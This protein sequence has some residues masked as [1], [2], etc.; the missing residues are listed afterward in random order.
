MRADPD[1]IKTWF[2]QDIA[3]CDICQ[4][5]LWYVNKEINGKTVIDYD[6]YMC[7]VCNVYTSPTTPRDCEMGEEY[8]KA[9]LDIA[10]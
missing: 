2:I 1:D 10:K 5:K 4:N 9:L 6:T 7:P 8:R 3:I